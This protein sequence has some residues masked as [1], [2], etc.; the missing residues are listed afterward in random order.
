MSPIAQVGPLECLDCG[1][2]GAGVI[3]DHHGN[4]LCGVHFGERYPNGGDPAYGRVAPPE[5]QQHAHRLLDL[6][7]LLLTADEPVPWVI[8]RVAARECVTVI[9]G[10][11]GEGKSLLTQAF[12]GGVLC[13]STIAGIACEKGRV[14]MFDAENGP[15]IIAKRTKGLGLPLDGLSIYDA[16]GLNLER[17]EDWIA[18]ELGG[19]DLAVF[20]SLRTLAPGAKENDSDDM[21]PVMA[22]FRR[23]A[24]RSG[25]AVLVV[26]HRGKDTESDYRG[27]SAI[28]DQTDMMFVLA[29]AK[30]DSEARWRRELRCSKCRIDEEPVVRWI[31]IRHQRGEIALTEA[32]PYEPGG[33]KADVAKQALEALAAAGEPRRLKQIAEAI[34]RS[35][36]DGTLRRALEDLQGARQ[37]IPTGDGYALPNPGVKSAGTALAPGTQPP[38]ARCHLRSSG[39]PGTGT[40]T[41]ELEK[42]A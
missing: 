2:V 23:L 9:A 24:I 22:V 18:G 21:A 20:D 37:V 26:H 8:A 40:D 34:G 17:D 7:K 27:S 16:A 38:G 13:G 29:R 15:R 10:A 42:A 1:L 32:A 3:P 35:P 41:A 5:V 6:R 25:A 33:V 39:T 36:K 14:A 4:P 11:G 12:S 19:V 28:R 30:G 31:G